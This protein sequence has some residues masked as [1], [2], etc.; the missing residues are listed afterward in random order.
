M[1]EYISVSHFPQSLENY[2]PWVAIYGLIAPYG[3]CQCGCGDD[4]PIANHT[5]PKFHVV[6]G[7][8]QRFVYNHH[9]RK[10]LAERFW[11]KVDKRNID[12]CW[13]WKAALNSAG[14]GAFGKGRAHR[15]AYE[16]TYGPI[17]DGYYV[18]HKCDNPPCV[19]PAHLFVGTPTDNVVDMIAKGR[20]VSPRL[21]GETNPNAKLTASQVIEIRKR[22]ENGAKIRDLAQEYGLKNFGID[23]I[24]HRRTW[25]H[26]P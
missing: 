26:L 9:S 20:K 14:Y 7:L 25:R 23:H 18:C 8:P 6:K 12:E 10:P 2:A 13:E 3:K 21:S 19:N 24:V 11:S 4:A 17:P 15:I 16:L 22:Y 1:T 5:E